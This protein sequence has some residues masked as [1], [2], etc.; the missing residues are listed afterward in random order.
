MPAIPIWGYVAAGS[1]AL[2][3]VGGWTVQ[4]WRWSAEDAKRLAAEVKA[5][6]K[7]LARQ[8]DIATQ[9][10]ADRERVRVEYITRE[11]QVREIFREIE[12]PSE[13]AAPPAVRELLTEAV[14]SANSAAREPG[15]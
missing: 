8:N 9:Y 5:K 13:C 11:G 1:L 15:G 12:V 10:E 6:D 3:F 2:G 14:A 7:Q 4:G